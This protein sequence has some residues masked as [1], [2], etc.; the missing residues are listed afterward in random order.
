MGRTLVPITMVAAMAAFAMAALIAGLMYYQSPSWW[1]AAVQLAVLGGIL[2]MIYAVNFRI[3]PVLSRRSWSSETWLHLQVAFAISGAWIAYASRIADWDAGLVL[4]HG[5]AFAGGMTFTFNLARLFRQPLGRAPAPPLPYDGHASV[6]KLAT[7]FTRLSGVYLLVGLATGFLTT[8][9]RPDFGHWDLVWAHALLVGF[10]LSLA[11]GVCYHVLARWTGR[12]WR[13]QWAIR[14]HLLVV[15]IGLPFM[16]LALA[17]DWMPLFAIAGPLQAAAIVLFLANVAPMLG[18]L[19]VRTSV[20]FA[21]A[22]A[23]LLTGVGMGATFAVEPAIGARLRLVHAEL[24][25]FGWAGL[26]ICGVGYYL[27]PRFLGQLLRWPL[28]AILQLGSLMTGVLLGVAALWWN[29]CGDGSRELI[30][31]AQS[32]VALGF[33]LYGALIAFT[34]LGRQVAGVIGSIVLQPRSRQPG[35]G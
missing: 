29:A 31:V 3:V 4:G 10:F 2:P 34:F 8:W 19:P 5:L 30:L 7:R 21:I 16:L 35:G 15:V 11:A 18:G 26:L 33:F 1:L 13:W 20:P 22:G 23:C 12:R 24:N 32:M 6:D 9:R 17:S 27:I 14:L 28:L 25:L